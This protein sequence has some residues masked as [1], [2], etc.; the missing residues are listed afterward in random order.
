[1]KRLGIVATAEDSTV[2]RPQPTQS[3]GWPT[4]M[5]SNTRDTLPPPREQSLPQPPTAPA[6]PRIPGSHSLIIPD[7][8][9]GQLTFSVR[10]GPEALTTIATTWAQLYRRDPRA[11]P[12]QSPEWI[13]SWATHLPTDHTPLILLV[14]HR[15]GAPLA[16][17]VLVRDNAPQ[18]TA[19]PLSSPHAEYI[20]PVGP[21]S[22]DPAVVGRLL[23]ALEAVARST[24]IILPDVPVA[25]ELGR[26][27]AAH[28]L[29][30]HHGFSKGV[31]IALPFTYTE[32]PPVVR[33]A[34]QRRQRGWS[35]MAG[36]VQYH[37]T[38]TMEDLISYLD[39]LAA[40]HPPRSTGLDVSDRRWRRIVEECGP[41]NALIA[42]LTV[43]GIPAATRLCL[44]RGQRYY[45]LASAVEP[46]QRD[47]APEHALLRSLIHDLSSTHATT[48]DLGSTHD[49]D[50]G[51]HAHKGQYGP[52]KIT[53]V[54]F[55]T[56]HTAHLADQATRS[57]RRRRR[58]IRQPLVGTP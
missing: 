39:L 16:A 50:E 49:D 25:S 27:L 51:L 28:P 12:Y 18:P 10:Q 20:R 38:R 15:D 11:T 52:L 9:T 4:P 34:H 58:N 48:L 37:R 56:H 14:Q 35:E 23:Q 30:Q 24:M 6:C 17:L 44:R 42:M 2:P 33:R 32:L 1:M 41:D 43:D 45:S 54:A 36:R 53:T 5:R 26:Q 21:L 29:W 3:R 22:E 46:T 13:T 47:T 57:R 7:D 40:M 19:S 8:F 55:S 31:E